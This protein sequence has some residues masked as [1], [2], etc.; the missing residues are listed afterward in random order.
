M[1]TGG[2]GGGVTPAVAV[3]A[4]KAKALSGTG[5]RPFD[6]RADGFV[7]SEGA[8]TFVLKRL[9]DAIGDGDRVYAVVR[10]VGASSDGR[11][12]SMYAPDSARQALAV[13]RAYV[14][15]GLAPDTVQDVECHATSTPVGDPAE[16]AAL[17]EVF[18]ASGR[19]PLRIGSVKAQIGHTMSAAGAAGLLKTVLGLDRKT[20]PPMPAVQ[21]PIDAVKEGSPFRLVTAPEPWPAPDDGQPR[22][23][24]VNAFGFG[25][26]NWHVV[27]EEFVPVYHA[28]LLASLAAPPALQ[29]EPAVDA[30]AEPVPLVVAGASAAPDTLFMAAGNTAD[31]MRAALGRLDPA[32]RRRNGTEAGA[33]HSSRARRPDFQA[34]ADLVRS[35]TGPDGARLSWMP[36]ASTPPTGRLRP[37]AP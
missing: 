34:K 10:G 31:E 27:V 26:T 17:R 9:R 28:A 4:S 14:D 22:R 2:V 16:V 18:G 15:S 30:A 13:S 11:G 6:A 12:H 24:G 19:G 33:S 23:A 32:G 20:L 3:I 21:Q 7:A 36:R 35:I 29:A 8:A 1:V 37:A 5:T 25:G